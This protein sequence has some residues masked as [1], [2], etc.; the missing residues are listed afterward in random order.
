MAR[1]MK[2]SAVFNSVSRG[3]LLRLSGPI[4]IAGPICDTLPR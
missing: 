4:I 1:F 3:G 2:S